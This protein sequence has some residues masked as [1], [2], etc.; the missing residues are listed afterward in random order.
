MSVS[1]PHP[2]R[3]SDLKK[4]WEESQGICICRF[5]P[6][7]GAWDQDS[8]P[9]L[10]SPLVYPA[11]VLIPGTHYNPTPPIH[12]EKLECMLRYI[13]LEIFIGLT[14][15]FVLNTHFT[16]VLCICIGTGAGRYQTCR[17]RIHFSE[18]E[19]ASE[20]CHLCHS[21]TQQQ[22]F[23]HSHKLIPPSLVILQASTNTEIK[24]LKVSIFTLY[25]C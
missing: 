15:C 14:W 9:G 19:T 17:K 11:R 1:L 22:K 12:L 16:Q 23:E 2:Q 5:L 6:S 24:S 7:P 20:L 25:G 13:F 4:R 21:V 3:C 8:L 18:T 10:F